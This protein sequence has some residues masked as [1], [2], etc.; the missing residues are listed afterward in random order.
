MQTLL[1]I[2]GQVV[3]AGDVEVPTYNE[4]WFSAISKA[5]VM[6]VV[7]LFEILPFT[8]ISYQL[9]SQIGNTTTLLV[10]CFVACL[11]AQVMEDRMDIVCLLVL[12]YAAVICGLQQ[13]AS[14]LDRC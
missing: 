10:L 14:Q 8:L 5:V 11:V 2:E 6:F 1:R 13:T 9:I 3:K 4:G 7:F 12:A